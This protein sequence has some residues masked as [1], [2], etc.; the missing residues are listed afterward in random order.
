MQIIGKLLLLL[1]LWTSHFPAAAISPAVSGTPR[2]K[3]V[4]QFAYLPYRRSACGFSSLDARPSRQQRFMLPALL[5]ISVMILLRLSRR[6]SGH[7]WG[8]MIPVLLLVGGTRAAT[9]SYYGGNKDEQAFAMSPTDDGGVYLTGYTTTYGLGR[10]STW[11]IR[12]DE[13]GTIV[14]QDTIGSLFYDQAGNAIDTTADGGCIVAGYCGN[15]S[16]VTLYSSTGS[17]L[18]QTN[19]TNMAVAYAVKA[20]KVRSGYAVVGTIYISYSPYGMVEVLTSSLAC[21]YIVENVAG[22]I[23]SGVMETSDGG[24]AVT[25]RTSSYLEYVYTTYNASNTITYTSTVAYGCCL[26]YMITGLILSDGN[27]LLVGVTNSVDSTHFYIWIK[28]QSLWGSRIWNMAYGSGS[29]SYRPSA[30]EELPNGMIAITGNVTVNSPGEVKT[31]FILLSSEGNLI[32]STTLDLVGDNSGTGIHYR[33]N[34]S[35]IIIS[36][37]AITSDNGFQYYVSTSTYMMCLPGQ[38]IYEGACKDCFAGCLI[39]TNVDNCQSCGSSYYVFNDSVTG[40][41]KCVAACPSFYY[42]SEGTCQPCGAGCK[43]CISIKSCTVCDTAK[44]YRYTDTAGAVNCVSTCPESYRISGMNC[45]PCPAGCQICSSQGDCQRCLPDYFEYQSPNSSTVSK[46]CVN[47]CPAGYYGD[48]STGICQHC[49][50]YCLTC[51]AGPD[52]DQCNSCNL[53]LAYPL[54]DFSSTCVSDCQSLGYYLLDQV[55]RRRSS[56]NIL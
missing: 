17:M 44:P 30:A 45:I 1:I 43:T 12:V 47:S 19:L 36:G 29:A 32:S 26:D 7:E 46:Q 2:P 27:V 31:C 4:Q 37:Y 55:C 25:G 34:D 10:Q 14:W 41:E 48:T 53:T 21:S 16:C 50:S 35:T 33:A 56:L 3:D 13:N 6:S 39:C 9:V 22:K 24:L 18:V 15:N 23:Y 52:S 38:F 11:T 49:H 42:V 28:K 51:S 5:L 40:H 54:E 8:I 20:L